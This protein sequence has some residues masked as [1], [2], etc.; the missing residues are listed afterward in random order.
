MI[1]TDSTPAAI[2][3]T[4]HALMF[5]NQETNDMSSQEF[6]PEEQP[7][8]AAI[9]ATLQGS[10]PASDAPSWTLGVGA[11]SSYE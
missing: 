9:D 11:A 7:G 1:S 5:V 6:D 10:F 2:Q 3:N 4:L 8:E